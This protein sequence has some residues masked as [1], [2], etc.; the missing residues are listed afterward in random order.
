MNQAIKNLMSVGST[1][2]EAGEEQ[3][4]DRVQTCLNYEAYLTSI[5]APSREELAMQKKKK[6]QQ[7]KRKAKKQLKI[8]VCLKKALRAANNPYNF[9]GYPLEKCQYAPNLKMNVYVPKTYAKRTLSTIPEEFRKCCAGCFLTPCLMEEFHPQF[10]HG[11]QVNRITK[12][13][14]EEETR[15]SL[16][17]DIRVKIAKVFNKTYLKKIL[18]NPF[19][20]PFCAQNALKKILHEASIQIDGGSTDSSSEDDTDVEEISTFGLPKAFWDDDEDDDIPDAV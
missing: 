11:A 4:Y 14:S 15:A 9:Q 19:D 2:E 12:G 18:P 10:V 16:C 13:R 17:L 6:K 8:N 3:D 7:P 1:A 5:T 20:I